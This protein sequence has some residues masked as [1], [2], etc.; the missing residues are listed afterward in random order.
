MMAIEQNAEVDFSAFA[1]PA[2]FANRVQVGGGPGFIRLAFSETGS[3]TGP[4]FYRAAVLMTADDAR[5]L[6]EAILA[7]LKLMQNPS[8]KVPT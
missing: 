5:S 2:I 3:Q 8:P 4:F 1:V 6:A 7:T